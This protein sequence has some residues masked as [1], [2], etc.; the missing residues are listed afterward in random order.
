MR[1][2]AAVHASQRWC[3]IILIIKIQILSKVDDILVFCAVA[4][5]NNQLVSH[6][7]GSNR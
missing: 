2:T 1:V 5:V 3:R 4:K 7:L 6:F